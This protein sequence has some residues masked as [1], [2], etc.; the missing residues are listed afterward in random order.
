[1]LIK[2]SRRMTKQQNGIS[3]DQARHPASALSDT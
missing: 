1:M 3:A 2:L